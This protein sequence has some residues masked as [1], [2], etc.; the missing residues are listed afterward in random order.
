MTERD[1]DSICLC[2]MV[3]MGFVCFTAF[4]CVAMT[5]DSKKSPPPTAAEKSP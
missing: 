5:L 2:V 4:V 1:T 3:C